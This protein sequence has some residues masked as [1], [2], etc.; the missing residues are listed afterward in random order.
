MEHT[1]FDKL[2]Q[3]STDKLIKKMYEFVL[4]I[5]MEDE[6]KDCMVKWAQNFGYNIDIDHSS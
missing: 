6:I 4:N 1:P 5:K 2:L 3:G